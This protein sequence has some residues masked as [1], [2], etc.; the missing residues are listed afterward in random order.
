MRRRPAVVALV[1][2]GILAI[3]ILVAEMAGADLFGRVGT[4]AAGARPPI[5]V[6]LL[7]SLSGPLEPFERPMHDAEI[8]ALEEIN[9]RG[10]I[11]GR[12][13]EWV[14]ADGRS[15]PRTFASQARRLIENGKASVVIGGWTSECRKAVRTVVEELNSLLIFPAEFEGLERSPR[16][17]YAGP[18]ANQQVIPGVRWGL[19]SLGAKKPFILASDEVWSRTVAAIAKDQLR[20]SGIEAAGELNLPVGGNDVGPAVAA[21][22]GA[23]PDLILNFLVG[24]A[25]TT[26]FPALRRAGLGA[27][28]VPIISFRV[29]E[30]D[31]RRIVAE[32]LAGHYVASDYFSAIDLPA[33][34]DFVRRYKAK[35]GEDRVA[36][37]PV[38]AAHDAVL[39]WAKA[40]EE[41]GDP[42][43]GRVLERLPRSS[44]DSPGGVITI[45]P[46]SLA[47]WRPVFM[48]RA[49]A[50][51]QFDVVWSIERSIRPLTY[52]VTRSTAEWTSFL[53]DLRSGWRGA[54][55]GEGKSATGTPPG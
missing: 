49:R 35:H 46:E 41:A 6:G 24:D 48:G 23:Q 37:A 26:L 3:G 11:G 25:N 4:L 39:L 47:V 55:S 13:V 14:E 19:E 53:D 30:E 18:S 36:S 50:D 12:R 10:G 52:S 5:V 8:F 27:G 54:W 7:H 33:N 51:G 40:V 34:R 38:V 1:G 22:A 32:D 16:I 20:V 17:I 45:D 43:P 15:D 42:D 28:R 44:L 2:C 9:A 31:S 29:S 21:I